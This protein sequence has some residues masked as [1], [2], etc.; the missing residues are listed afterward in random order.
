[1]PHTQL[2]QLTASQREAVCHVEGPLQVIAGPGSGKTR[3][4]TS[5][6]AY[7]VSQG[8]PPWNICAIT[9]TNKA[10][11]EMRQRAAALGDCGRAHISTFHSLCVRVL[12]RYAETVQLK[13]SFSIFDTKDQSK[14]IKQAV[15]DCH[16]DSSNFPPARMLHAISTLKN[17]CT[18]PEGFLDQ[19]YD[20]FSRSLAQ[21]YARY[22]KLLQQQSA[23][24][25]DDLLMRTA[26]LLEENPNVS[27]E[28]ADRFRFL[29]IDEY[30]DTNHAQY[31]IAQ[32]IAVHHSNICATGDP[33]QSIYRWRGA[34]LR[35]ILAFEED[36]PQAKVVR[37]EEN[38]RSTA[39]ILKAADK[40]I[41]NNQHRKAKK[42]VPTLAA[43]EPIALATCE[44]EFDEADHIACK[45]NALATHGVSLNEVAIFYR[46]NAMSRPLEESLVRNSVP[47]Q[48]VRG[49]EF[50]NRK[51][52]KDM[53]AYLKVLVNPDDEIA[54]LRVINTPARGIGKVTLERVKGYALQQGLNFY[55]A[56][57]QATFID[58]LTKAVQAKLGA[59]VALVEGLKQDLDLSVAEITERIFLDSGLET[60][61]QKQGE[62]GK[63]ARD[64]VTEL[65]NGA[66]RY[67][68]LT[69]EGSLIDYLQQISLFSDTDAYNAD[70]QRVALM[71]LHAA[72]G[73]E[74]DHVFMVGLEE[75]LLP[76][77]RSADDDQE[78]EEERRLCFV[79]ITRARKQLQMSHAKFRTV[80]GQTLRTVA[81]PFLRECGLLGHPAIRTS[82]AEVHYDTSTSQQ[83]QTKAPFVKG[84]LVRHGKFGLGRVE[85]YQDMGESS[86][87]T[88]KFNTGPT[89]TLMLKY[90][91][92]EKA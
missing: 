8:V 13:S 88:V 91:K 2:D 59:F 61:L 76:H 89:K 58:T 72:K 62:E 82:V 53:L 19:A 77:E 83:R 6:L 75:G 39:T 15:K 87:I 79:G 85:S 71:S 45:I 34:D 35:N 64:N 40:L 74:F 73:L 33:D 86:T 38:F 81:S 32:N 47:Y 60:S 31:R 25:F 11:E 63:E 10:A 36:W 3:V 52:I 4:I 9:F 17:K 14:C 37:L 16:L 57:T 92:L 21:V 28:L 69:E 51:E 44:D 5:R 23:V 29:M 46:V 18:T 80:R 56:L 41:A 78:L 26:L 55:Q 20:Y 7:L 49:V 54:L 27:K 67:D 84:Q 30:Q 65:I 12:R 68:E 22:Q 48:I 70:S 43:G 90:A 66:A 42:L 50:Y 1:M 24:D